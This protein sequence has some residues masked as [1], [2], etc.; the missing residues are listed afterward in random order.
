MRDDNDW[1]EGEGFS[2]P[3]KG[4]K[5]VPEEPLTPPSRSAKKR[6]GG[7]RSSSESYDSMRRSLVIVACFSIA[8]AVGAMLFSSYRTMQAQELI[9]SQKANQRAV[10]VATREIAPG[11]ALAAS[12]LTEAAVPSALVPVDAVSVEEADTLLGKRVTVRLSPG[13]PVSASAVRQSALPATLASAVAEGHV[14]LSLSL[15]EASGVSPLLHVGDMVDVISL[16]DSTWSTLIS[17][18]RVLALDEK[19]GSEKTD[20][21]SRVTLEL[22]LEDAVFVSAAERVRLALHPADISGEA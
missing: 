6:K 14:A 18:V 20:G 22:T 10:L 9:D 4:D 17:S 2:M 15:D 12:D 16:A 8:V 21:Y 1:L 13:I 7:R 3:G 11:E 5:A 19:L